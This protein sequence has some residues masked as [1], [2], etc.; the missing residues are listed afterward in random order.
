MLE[1]ACHFAQFARR[2]AAHLALV[3]FAFRF[4][5]TVF[6]ICCL[7]CFFRFGIRR[8]QP[9]AWPFQETRC[10]VLLIGQFGR[11]LGIILDERGLKGFLSQLF[12]RVA[13]WVVGRRE[14]PTPTR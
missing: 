2:Y 10:S 7:C 6:F 4:F 1:T 13:S 11:N 8:W 12:F 14:A 5:K 9:W 3:Q